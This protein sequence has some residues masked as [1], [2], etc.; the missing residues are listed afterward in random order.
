[1]ARLFSKV[2][3]LNLDVGEDLLGI[4]VGKLAPCDQNDYAARKQ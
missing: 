1:M 3:P 2:G 4:A